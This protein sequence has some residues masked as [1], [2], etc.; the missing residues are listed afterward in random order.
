M[1]LVMREDQT[2]TICANFVVSPN[3]WLRPGCNRSWLWNAADCSQFPLGS[4]F[5]TKTFAI[6]LSNS[7][8]AVDFKIAFEQ[9]AS[10]I[11]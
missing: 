10:I 8:D 1:R 4:Q 6:R 9:G 5:G 3:M 2:Q 7:D 11:N